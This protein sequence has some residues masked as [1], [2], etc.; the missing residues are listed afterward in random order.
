VEKEWNPGYWEILHEWYRKS[1]CGGFLNTSFNLHG[2]P[3]VKDAK[4]ALWTMENS[5]LN[6]LVVDD[7]VITK[8]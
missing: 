8:S 2:Y 3:I 7:W 1:G 4:V 5:D 6:M